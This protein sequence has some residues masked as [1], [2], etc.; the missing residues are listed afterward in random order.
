[1]NDTLAALTLDVHTVTQLYLYLPDICI[2]DV[3]CSSSSAAA[4]FCGVFFLIALYLQHIIACIL[5][6]ESFGVK[7]LVIAIIARLGQ[8]FIPQ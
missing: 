8:K 2:S 4:L 7:S 3:D 1:M 6:V 5:C